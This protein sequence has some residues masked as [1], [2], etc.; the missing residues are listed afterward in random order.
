MRCTEA[1]LQSRNKE[2]M[3]RPLKPLHQFSL[4]SSNFRTHLLLNPNQ[5]LCAYDSC[6]WQCFNKYMLLLREKIYGILINP[7]FIQSVQFIL[8]RFDM[9]GICHHLGTLF[10]VPVLVPYTHV[11]ACIYSA[12]FYGWVKHMLFECRFNL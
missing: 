11:Q 8:Y 12:S 6:K 5:F 3:K 10:R 1:M 7:L 2:Y 9:I 4:L